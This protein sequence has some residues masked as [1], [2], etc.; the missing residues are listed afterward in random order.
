[1]D[2]NI[3]IL[4]KLGLLVFTDIIKSGGHA[5]SNIA[6]FWEDVHSMKLDERLIEKVINNSTDF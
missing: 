6:D 4:I 5:Q 1:M 3:K 2:Y